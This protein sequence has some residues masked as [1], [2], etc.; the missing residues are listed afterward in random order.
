MNSAP[1]SRA[2]FLR[3]PFVALF[4]AFSVINWGTDYKT[5]LY[6]EPAKEHHLVAIAKLLSENERPSANQK[7]AAASPSAER[8]SGSAASPAWFATWSR[9]TAFYQPKQCKP[10][11]VPPPLPEAS[12]KFLFYRPPPARIA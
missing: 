4:V 9:P 6:P 12:T 8:S 3:L 2:L 10:G 1:K 11:A 7:L 5:S